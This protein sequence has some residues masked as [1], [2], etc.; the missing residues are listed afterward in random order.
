MKEFES[1]LNSLNKNGVPIKKS[2]YNEKILGSWFIEIDFKPPYRIV[3]DG[4]DRTIVL[5]EMNNSE[6]KS[7]LS[8]KTRSGKHILSKVLN[9]LN[10]IK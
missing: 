2:S 9:K 6:W 5:E 8:D 1:I 10:D 4:R 7:I 3:H